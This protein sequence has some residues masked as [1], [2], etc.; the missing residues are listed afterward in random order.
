MIISVSSNVRSGSC[1][2]ILEHIAVMVERARRTYGISL[3]FH[4][5]TEKS[6]KYSVGG[7]K[8]PTR[9]TPK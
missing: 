3:C 1:T 6:T 4:R 7:S 2:V 8:R 9:V 5:G